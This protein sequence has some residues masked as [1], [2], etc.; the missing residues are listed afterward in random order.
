MDSSKK[1][2][3]SDP[4]NGEG[5]KRTG[6]RWNS[7]GKAVIYCSESSST[8]ILEIL[9]GL[10]NATLLQDYVGVS[11][12]LPSDEFSELTVELLEKFQKKNDA[13]KPWNAY[14]H[15]DFTSVLGDYWLEDGS[16]L[17]LRVPCS[18][19]TTDFNIL[20]NPKHKDFPLVKVLD[21]QLTEISDRLVIEN[22]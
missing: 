16:F 14:P 2:Y 10:N 8:A 22:Y 1:K 17:A 3:L 6:G 13:I 11:I 18:L 4:L 5:A 21:V 15:L 20:I 19:S 12:K 7:T 9:G